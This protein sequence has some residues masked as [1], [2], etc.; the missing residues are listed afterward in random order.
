MFKGLISED[1]IPTK[2]YLLE[3]LISRNRK[4]DKTSVKEELEDKTKT[5]IK[6]AKKVWGNGTFNYSSTVFHSRGVVV[7]HKE[8]GA[9]WQ[10]P[11]SH[12][13]GLFPFGTRAFPVAKEKEIIELYL[14]GKSSIELGKKYN[15]ADNTITSIL[16]KHDI[17]IRGPGRLTSKDKDLI[18]RRWMEGKI[19]SEITNEFMV[20]KTT[21]YK[22]LEKYGI[23]ADKKNP[24]SP[25]EVHSRRI[26]PVE[27]EDQIFKDY[28]SDTKP[29]VAELSIK[30]GY[31]ARAIRGVI[32]RKG[33][34]SRKYQKI[35]DEE[36]EVIRKRYANNDKTADL[37]KEYGVNTSAI[38]TRLHR[39]GDE[40]K[41]NQL[42]PTK[43]DENKIIEL[44][45]SGY[46]SKKISTALGYSPS[47]ILVTLKKYDIDTSR[48]PEF[49]SRYS[50][51]EEKKFIKS[52]RGRLEKIYKQAKT[53]TH[54]QSFTKKTLDLIGCTPS[55]LVSHLIETKP[56]RVKLENCHLDHIIP[57]SAFANFT[58]NESIIKLVSHYQNLQLL[59]K[60]ENMKKGDSVEV[61]LKMLLKKKP[62]DKKTYKL[63]LNFA[64]DFIKD[65]NKL[66][67]EIIES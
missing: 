54:N 57:I 37:A 36:F 10:R 42:S 40:V 50:S 14:S 3:I 41:L 1:Q 30:Y 64:Q 24:R 19:I 21:I 23:K 13:K 15:V 25:K 5:F 63:L 47:L 67:S 27:V 46:G 31:S 28:Q 51:D 6:K 9:V 29:Y 33:G 18:K 34:K 58:E 8:F 7:I 11:E 12:L 17:E 20:S 56:P 44:Y 59:S 61:G 52:L 35:S 55:E 22:V 4:N 39:I 62:K 49:Y 66:M 26:I 32:K 48:P 45:K 16:R 38:V 43:E 2:E 60:K 65:Q 53:K